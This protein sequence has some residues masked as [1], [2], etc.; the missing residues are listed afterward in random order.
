MLLPMK[1]KITEIIVI[2]ITSARSYKGD[3]LD[4]IKILHEVYIPPKIR[5]RFNENY[6]G[7]IIKFDTEEEVLAKFRKDR[8]II[9]SIVAMSILIGIIVGYCIH[10]F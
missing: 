5:E 3:A 2:G 4:E 9:L 1:E 8:R 10:Y 6:K 7:E